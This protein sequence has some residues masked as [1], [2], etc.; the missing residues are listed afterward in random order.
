MQ[1]YMALRI[2][3]DVGMQQSIL[4]DERLVYKVVLP[5]KSLESRHKDL[6]SLK[7]SVEVRCEFMSNSVGTLGHQEFVEEGIHQV[8]QSGDVCALREVVSLAP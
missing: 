2:D 4:H 5:D 6:G 8:M 3:E 7:L 1:F